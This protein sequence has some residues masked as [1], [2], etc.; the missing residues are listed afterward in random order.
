MDYNDPAPFVQTTPGNLSANLPA[1]NAAFQTNRNFSP[2]PSNA[3]SINSLM[4]TQL[5]NSTS[6]LGNFANLTSISPL[7]S[8]SFAVASSLNKYVRIT[9]LICNLL[10]CLLV[11]ALK[12]VPRSLPLVLCASFYRRNFVAPH[13]KC[14]ASSPVTSNV[15]RRSLLIVRKRLPLGVVNN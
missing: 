13:S 14:F 2:G 1:T 12:N 4:N 15:F 6:N 10:I 9:E 7:T 5:N 8:D 11:L 3:S